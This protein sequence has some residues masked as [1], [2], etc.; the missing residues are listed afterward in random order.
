MRGDP[1]RIFYGQKK[2]RDCSV[3]GRPKLQISKT[4]RG[5]GA[6]VSKGS[7]G[8]VRALELA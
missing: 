7:E 5:P 2:Q 1:T 8:G 4:F 6:D 3:T